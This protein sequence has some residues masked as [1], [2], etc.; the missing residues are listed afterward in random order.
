MLCYIERTHDC[1]GCL[2]G[3]RIFGDIRWRRI[4][5]HITVLF[6]GTKHVEVR[7]VMC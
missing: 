1:D 4:F 5:F 7:L 3:P 2:I 6:R